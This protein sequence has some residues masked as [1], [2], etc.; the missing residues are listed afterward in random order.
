MTLA[1]K[2]LYIIQSKVTGAFKVGKSDDPERRLRQLQTG[3]PYLLRI[4][5]IMEES[6]NLE[7]RVHQYLKTYKTRFSS[8]GEWFSESGLGEIPVQVWEHARAWYMEDPDWW[9]RP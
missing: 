1:G 9:K 7:P 3:C 5:L 6:G 4:I 2:H 8:G